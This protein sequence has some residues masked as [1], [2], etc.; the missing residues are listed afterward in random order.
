MWRLGAQGGAVMAKFI[1][2]YGLA[3]IVCAFAAGILAWSKN[4]DYNYWATVSF[5]FPPALVMLALMPKNKHPP[6]S[7]PSLDEEDARL[8]HH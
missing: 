6:R 7:R 2:I 5:L 8:D 3:I 1:A 4:R